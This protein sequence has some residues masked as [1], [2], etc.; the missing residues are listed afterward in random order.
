MPAADRDTAMDELGRL[1]LL[2]LVSPSLPIGAFSYSQ[3]LEWAVEYGW[4]RDAGTLSGWLASSLESNVAG[5]DLPILARL[6]RACQAGDE[7]EVRHWSGMLLAYRE[8]HELRSEERSRGRALA[9][10]LMGLDV[11]YA[12]A[13]RE[14]LGLCQAAGFALASVKWGISLRAAALGYVWGWLENQITA[15]V[16]LIPLGQ[17]QGQQVL[18]ELTRS[19]PAAVRRGLAIQDHELGGATPALAIASSRH[20]TQYTRLFRS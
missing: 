20:E 9:T 4:V 15:G 1:R 7:D 8:T 12:E 18:F 16:K 3:G 10:L 17:T 14:T 19:L 2:H 11:E 5:I 6:Y 13:W